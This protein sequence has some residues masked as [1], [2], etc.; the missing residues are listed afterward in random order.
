MFFWLKFLQ[1]VI[2][3]GWFS[4]TFLYHIIFFYALSVD[5]EVMLWNGGV[6]TDADDEVVLEDE[7]QKSHVV[8]TTLLLHFFGR[9]GKQDLKF[10]EFKM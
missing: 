6:G 2:H 9:K 10:E 8:D 4:R 7:L 5:V 1:N 3:F